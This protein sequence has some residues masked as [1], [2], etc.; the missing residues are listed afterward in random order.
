GRGER[1]RHDQSPRTTSTRAGRTSLKMENGKWKERSPSSHLPFSIFHFPSTPLRA[2]SSVNSRAPELPPSRQTDPI[3]NMP[4]RLKPAR[5]KIFRAQRPRK[6]MRLFRVEMEPRGPT[7]RNVAQNL[8]RSCE[9][10]RRFCQKLRRFCE[11]LRR[12]CPKLRRSC[13]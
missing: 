8:R 4:R 1:L 2:V 10:L 5:V 11:N 3:E 12:F 13:E 9:N 7:T 6:E